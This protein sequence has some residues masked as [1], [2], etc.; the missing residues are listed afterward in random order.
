MFATT[1]YFFNDIEKPNI[2]TTFS[3]AINYSKN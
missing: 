1:T 2:I 3:H